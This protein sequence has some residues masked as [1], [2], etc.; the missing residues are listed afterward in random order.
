MVQLSAAAQTIIAGLTRWNAGTLLF[1]RDGEKPARVWTKDKQRIDRRMT[2][3]LKAIARVRGGNP[4]TVKL[5]PWVLHDLRR[6]VRTRLSELKVPHDV[7]EMILGHGKTGLDRVYDQ[8]E[9]QDEMREGLEKWAGRLQE[10]TAKDYPFS[11]NVI[12]LPTAREVRIETDQPRS[13]AK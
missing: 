5:E 2:L 7:R 6:T 4:Q 10:I 8:Y 12:T 9:F 1:S 13:A 11:S 3:T